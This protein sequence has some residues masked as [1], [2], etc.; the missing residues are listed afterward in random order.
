[1]RPSVTYAQLADLRDP[2]VGR[3][4]AGGCARTNLP[5]VSNCSTPSRTG[6]HTAPP[7]AAIGPTGSEFCGSGVDS[8]SPDAGMRLRNE[9]GTR[10]PVGP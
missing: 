7:T 10:P 6:T 3:R 1:M 4:R 8:G 9:S 5:L 2:A